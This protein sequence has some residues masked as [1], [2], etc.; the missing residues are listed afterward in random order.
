ML[1]G[2][3]ENG[4]R[5]S[6]RFSLM[7]RLFYP[8]AKQVYGDYYATILK[9]YSSV[10]LLAPNQYVWVSL[11]AKGL[12]NGGFYQQVRRLLPTSPS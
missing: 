8:Q 9:Q 12:N 6:S 3:K 7:A 10:L 5:T 4:K 11:I 2:A 1:E